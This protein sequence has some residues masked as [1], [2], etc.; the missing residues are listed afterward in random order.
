[1]PKIERDLKIVN[2]LGLHAR[3]AI[4]LV[5]L[6]QQFDAEVTVC[7]QHKQAPANS[8]M[9]LLMLETAQGHAIRVMAEGPDAEAALNA[10]EQLVADRFNE[11][12]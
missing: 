7:N 8:V 5:Q 11:S 9:G 10:V 12:E 6:T 4:Q 2:K 3:A 1:M